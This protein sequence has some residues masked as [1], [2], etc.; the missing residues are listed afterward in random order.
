MGYQLSGDPAGLLVVDYY[1]NHF[2]GAIVYR[3]LLA[4]CQYQ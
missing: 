2:I 1:A 4:F 3:A